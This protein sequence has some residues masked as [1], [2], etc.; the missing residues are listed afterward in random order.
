MST[1]RGSGA[2]N[3]GGVQPIPAGSRKMVQSLKEIVNC[4]EAEIYAT[5]KDCN[6]D[7]NEAVN[8]LLSQDPFHEVKSKR[9]KKKEGKDTTESRSRGA[10][11]NSS[12]GGKIGADRYLSRDHGG[13]TSYNSSESAPLPGK[14]SYKKE[15]GSTP[16]ASSLSSVPGLSGNRSRGPA[17]L[18]DGASAEIKGSS[19]GTAD[20]MPSGIQPAS[21]Y[22]SA[23]VGAPGQVSMADIVKMGRPHNK[24]SNPANASHHYVQ[25]PSTSA[26]HHNLR[27]PEDHASKDPESGIS[28]VHHLST[29]EEWPSIEKPAATNV[30][31]VPEYTVD[32]EQHLEASGVPSDSINRHSEAEEVQEA[33][34]DDIENSGANDV[35]S[36]SMSSRK[37]PEDDSRGASLFEDDLYENMGSYEH[38]AHDFHEDVAAEEIGA[39]VSS[40]TRNLHQLSVKKDDRG[41]PSEG[42]APSVV[43]PDHLQVQNAD[44]SHLSFGSFGSGMSAVYSSGAMTSVP[45][46]PN[47]EEP[48]GDA[49]ISSVGHLD[50]RSSEYYVDDSL[51]NASDG[52]LYHRTSASAGSYDPSSTAQPE[53][54]KHENAEVAQGNQYS[55][56]SSNPGYTFDDAQHLNASFSQTSSQ[57]QNLAPFSNVMQSYTNSLPSTLSPADVH[58]SRESDLQ[59]S[60]FPVTQ[61]LSTKYGNSV[62]SIGGSAISMSEALKTAGFSSTQ[63]APQTLS[64]TSVATGP[65]LPQHLAVHPYSQPTLPLG[66]FTNMIGY[67]FLPQ[68][69]TYMPSAFQQTFAGNSTYHQSL[70]AVLPQYKN[71]VSASSLPQS[72]AIASGYGAFGNTTTIPGN[73]PMNPPPAPSGATLSYDD[74]LS[75]QYKDSSHLVSLQQNENSGMWLHGPNSRTMSAV[76]ASTY[77]NYQGQNQQ[78]GGF[79]Q[80]QQPSQNYGALGYPNFYHSQTGISLDQQQN[81]RDGSLVS[82]QGQP[83]QSQIWQ[84]SY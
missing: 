28:L 41:L 54:L 32:S 67:P 68:S 6:M 79:R 4:S 18:S 62:S 45:V 8:R 20:A 65:P 48:H 23:W 60:P 72:A 10:N 77:Y 38:Q 30:I 74:V 12:R 46:K 43:I 53:E 63:P 35:G 17:G 49:D 51:R 29:N 59:Y 34:D 2:G 82:S 64:G 78:T 44:C 61:S 50:T 27:F 24:A 76:P 7:P 11:N 25:G 73:F 42:Y 37:I 84:N 69:Y 14:S 66:P 31:P 83:K 55:F 3:G 70:A 56:P 26:S 40:V 1:S 16:Y 81:P 80:G 5:L 9:E 21:G 47:L 15:N 19:L 58:P 22:Q 57:M 52:G 36:D 13:S 71:N 39:S 75:S 33:E